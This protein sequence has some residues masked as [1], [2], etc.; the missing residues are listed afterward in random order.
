MAATAQRNVDDI[1]GANV[2]KKIR[3]RRKV[4]GCESVIDK[5]AINDK[6]N[7]I[8]NKP[9]ALRD[10]KVRFEELVDKTPSKYN[11]NF[12]AYN[13]AM[14]G[15][16]PIDRAEFK[17]LSRMTTTRYKNVNTALRVGC[18]TN[19][20][21]CRDL[22]NE[23]SVIKSAL[24]KYEPKVTDMDRLIR[25]EPE[26]TLDGM[27]ASDFYQ[28]NKE[29]QF[30]SFIHT[31]KNADLNVEMIPGG[32][33]WERYYKL[34]IKSESGV[35]MTAFVSNKQRHAGQAEVL[36]P[37]GTKFKVTS[38]KQVEV[39]RGGKTRTITEVELDEIK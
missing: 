23:I 32:K 22:I 28:P 35:D 5:L 13:E 34:K 27:S 6:T 39:V 25:I 15:Y 18:N 36:L 2:A 9:A 12:D 30:D 10:A 7:D 4:G 24:K 1:N 31:S 21:Q 16:P 33:D 20:K 3:C 14:H 8:L 29:I 38:V 11:A 19:L 26:W 37:A 17:A